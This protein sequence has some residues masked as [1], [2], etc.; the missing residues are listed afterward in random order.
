M[1]SA[2]GKHLMVFGIL[3]GL[4]HAVWAAPADRL[5]EPRPEMCVPF[6]ADPADGEM[7]TP[8]GLAYGDVRTA[9]NGVIQTALYCG[10]P[11]GFTEV[12]LTF[13]LS[14]GCD[15]VVSDIETI[16]DDEA[17]EE[18]VSCISAV[19]SKA[20]FPAH[21]IEGGMPVTYPVNV[22]W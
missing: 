16:E 1:T 5:P 9:L 20:D 12:H 2:R 15:G 14:V 21:D 22:A 11:D 19:I 4:A 8:A 6:D 13:E 7:A 10:Q 3:G 17:P 18:Y